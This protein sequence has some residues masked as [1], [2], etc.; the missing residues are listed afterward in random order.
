MSNDTNNT[1]STA[2]SV[3]QNSFNISPEAQAYFDYY[4]SADPYYA[5]KSN[6]QL[7]RELYPEM[8]VASDGASEVSDLTLS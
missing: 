6:L 2:N 4:R 1:P 8:A 5:N 7:I 3:P